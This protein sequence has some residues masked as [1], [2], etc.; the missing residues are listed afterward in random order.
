MPTRRD[1]TG[2]RFGMLTVI[3]RAPHIVTKIGRKYTAWRCKCDCGNEKVVQ[4]VFLLHGARSCG[5]DYSKRRSES[6]KHKPKPVPNAVG[7][8]YGRLVIIEE[9]PRLILS[10]GKMARHMRC[11]CDCGKI[12]NVQYRYMKSLHTR[13][14]GCWHDDA[15]LKHGGSVKNGEYNRLYHVWCAMRNRCINPDD[16]SYANYGGRGIKICD[17]W[18]DN[19]PAFRDWALATGYDPKADTGVST[20]DRIDNN[21]NYCP[22][23]CRWADREAQA[24]NKRDTV[25]IT[26]D[27]E[28]LSISQWMRRGNTVCRSVFYNRVKNGW[29]LEEALF[30][31]SKE[32]DYQKYHFIEYNGESKRVCDWARDLGIKPSTVYNRLKWGWTAGE[33]LGLESHK[34]IQA[35]KAI[36][37]LQFDKNGNFIREWR[38]KKDIANELHIQC[39]TLNKYLKSGAA[40]THGWIW[41]LKQ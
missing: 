35:S 2:Q 3:E 19:F 1:L 20:I 6:L 32:W 36:H 38:T 27:G 28:T 12:V 31:P 26:H 25:K 9:L 30:T 24:N 16:K 34:T 33:A 14:C 17:E 23:N 18:V 13:S 41:R 10:T 22:E 29:D 8:R 37:V 15:P 11:Q 40:D 5:C 4:Q 39:S 7:E 21:G